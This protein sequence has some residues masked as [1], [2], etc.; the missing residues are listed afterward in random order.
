[1]SISS[2][3]LV[4][5][6]PETSVQVAIAAAWAQ[7][8]VKLSVCMG[9]RVWM[10]RGP[11]SP[12]LPF[13]MNGL[14]LPATQQAYAKKGAW[15]SRTGVIEGAASDRLCMCASGQS[16]CHAVSSISSDGRARLMQQ[17]LLHLQWKEGAL[18]PTFCHPFFSKF[19]ALLHEMK[20]G[21]EKKWFKKI[22]FL[23]LQ[24]AFTDEWY[25]SLSWRHMLKKQAIFV[26][27]NI[28]FMHS[29]CHFKKWITFKSQSTLQPHEVSLLIVIHK[30][31]TIIFEWKISFTRKFQYCYQ[32][33]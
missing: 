25:W 24:C 33:F 7:G 12:K 32:Q 13:R 20:R 16:V 29:L 27:E 8:S 18:A 10:G 31:S 4:G 11:V 1:M 26:L 2:T 23:V 28:Q 21:I 5:W 17:M 9:L 3:T 6:L 30:K 15:T 19:R 14:W 22:E